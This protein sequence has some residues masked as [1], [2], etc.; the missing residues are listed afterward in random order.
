MYIVVFLK[1][2]YGTQH[3]IGGM[4]RRHLSIVTRIIIYTSLH[5][6][7]LQSYCYLHTQD[8]DQSS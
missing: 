7:I 5:T 6:R 2:P 1:N 8:G 4:R 3:A